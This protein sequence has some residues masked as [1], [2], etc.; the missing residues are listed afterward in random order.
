M[1]SVGRY[2]IRIG[3]NREIL[4]VDVGVRVECGDQDVVRSCLEMSENFLVKFFCCSS[5][6]GSFAYHLVGCKFVQGIIKISK[7]SSKLLFQFFPDSEKVF[8]FCSF[9]IDG[10]GKFPGV[11][12]AFCKRI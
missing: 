7:Y 11:I 9:P 6:I 12:I 8:F 1:F 5:D 10:D 4:F 3:K 2:Q